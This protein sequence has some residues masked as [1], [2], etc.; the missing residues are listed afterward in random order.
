M[1]HPKSAALE[2]LHALEPDP[3]AQAECALHLLD[4]KHGKDVMM[5]ALAVLAG[6]PYPAARPVICQLYTTYAANKGV[7]DPGAYLRRSLIDALRPV[8]RRDDAELLAQAT[9]TYEFWPPDFGED[10]VLLRAAALV[11]LA[12][13]DEDLA[14][15]HAARLLV[16]PYVQ[17][18]SGEP[19]MTAARVL[20]AL[21]EQTPLY[22]YVMQAA[23]HT[24]PEVTAECLR[25]MTAA[26][27]ALVAG[28]VARFGKT[29]P[30]VVQVGLFDLL[31]QHACRATGTRILAPVP[32]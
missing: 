25:Q 31:I 1:A 32:G 26:P 19:A 21:G 11:A 6:N 14:R 23:E 16:D 18:M 17:P 3:A 2:K 30:T 12:E 28:L 7:R 29:A 15:Y 20:G 22:L 9:E 4:G 24:L 10:A 8:A 27:A 5:A 13:V